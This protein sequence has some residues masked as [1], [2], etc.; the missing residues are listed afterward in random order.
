MNR[1]MPWI[2]QAL[3][4]G[5]FAVFIGVF[6]SWP[7]YRALPPNQAL[8]KV[9]FIHHGQ[10]VA[11]CRPF[12]AEELAK[13]APNMRTP[14]K[15]ERERSPVTIELDLDGATVYRHVAAPSG[16]SRDGASSVYHR[17]AVPAGEHRF[18]VRLKDSASA[19]DF[20]HTRDA[21]LTL[22]PAQVLVIDFDAEKGGITLS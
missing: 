1:L 6:S 16:L 14:M 10:R 11:D 17:I 20:T 5:A 18:S 9:S 13:L 7:E 2:G 3:L 22:K 21:T 12:T 8:V 15:C 19:R 4:Y